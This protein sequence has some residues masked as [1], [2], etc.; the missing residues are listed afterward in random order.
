MLVNDETLYDIDAAP[1]VAMASP[2]TTSDAVATTP[3]DS[4]PL[5]DVPPLTSYIST[6]TET[7]IKG[8]KLV[9]DSIAQQRQTASSALIFHPAVIS[10]WVLMLAIISHYQ[11]HETSDIPLLLCTFAGATMA[12]LVAVRAATGDY[13]SKAEELTWRWLKPDGPNAEQ[14]TILVTQYGDEVMAALVLRLPPSTPAR[15]KRPAG[16]AYIR[17][18]TVRLRF[19][20]K[21]VGRALLEEAVLV[22]RERAGKDV[23]VVFADDHA[24]SGRVL[25]SLFNRVFDRREKKA[26]RM[27]E[28]VVEEV[29]AAQGGDKEKGGKGR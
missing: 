16:K 23:E 24:N 28:E 15:K 8:L 13:L 20:G 1:A 22:A 4:D 3:P 19:R 26:W 2:T 29:D 25:P 10:A 11:Y 21:G 17:G 6:D 18:W 9:A 14:D 5:A 7:T 27:L 12:A